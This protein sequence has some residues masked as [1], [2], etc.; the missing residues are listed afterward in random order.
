M[1]AVWTEADER[2]AMHADA[3]KAL[4]WAERQLRHIDS[5]IAKLQNDRDLAA[6]DVDI[7]RRW[8]AQCA[9]DIRGR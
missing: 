4:A 7:A 8:L 5:E 6:R 1:S 9:E 3:V 2:A